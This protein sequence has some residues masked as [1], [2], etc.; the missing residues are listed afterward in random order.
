MFRRK[1]TPLGV[2]GILEDGKG[3]KKNEQLTAGH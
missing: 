2:G 1:K 3:D